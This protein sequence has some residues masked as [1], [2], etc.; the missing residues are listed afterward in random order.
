VQRLE[1]IFGEYGDD[2][3]A[4]LY[5][6]SEEFG[7]SLTGWYSIPIYAGATDFVLLERRGLQ[8]LDYQLDE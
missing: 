8:E 7:D 1:S 4:S 2:Y 6:A 5:I 3:V